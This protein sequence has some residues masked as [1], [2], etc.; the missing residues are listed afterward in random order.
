MHQPFWQAVGE[1]LIMCLLRNELLHLA[2][3]VLH[4]TI[5]VTNTKHLPLVVWSMSE[6][7]DKQFCLLPKTQHWHSQ[8]NP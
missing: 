5:C 6:A 3:I 4:G 7:Y 2:H 1:I 8:N